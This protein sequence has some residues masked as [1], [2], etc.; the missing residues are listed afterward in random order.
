MGSEPKLELQLYGSFSCRWSDGT[1]VQIPGAKHRALLA[2]LAIGRN[3]TQSRTWLQSRLWSRSGEELG[4]QSL[5]RAISD[6]KRIFGETAYGRLFDVSN[7]DLRLRPEEVRICGGERDGPFLDGLTIR[8]PAFEEW[9]A[10]E[11]DRGRAD[12]ERPRP[13]IAISP[14]LAVVPFQ[15]IDGEPGTRDFADLFAAETTRA[16]SRSRMIDVISHL[17]CRSFSGGSLQL[18]DVRSQLD[19]DY[20]I[21]GA[22]RSDGRDFRLDADFIEAATGHIVWTHTFTGAIRDVLMGDSVIVRQIA[23]Q[24][25]Q[26]ILRSSVDLARSRPLPEVESHALFMASIA[27]MHQHRQTSFIQARRQLEE[28]IQRNPERSELYA[29][30]AKWYILAISQGWSDDPQADMQRAAQSAARGLDVDPVCSISLTVDGMIQ[31]SSLG[32]PD[33]AHSRFTEATRINP[34][35][36]LAWLMFGRMHAFLG[37]GE[38]AV[39]FTSRARALSPLDPLGYFYDAIAATAHQ[40]ADDNETARVLAE[41]SIASNP[42]HTSSYRTLAIAQELLDDHAA[43]AQT[44]ATLKR[45]E[46]DLTVSRYQARHPAGLMA[47]GQRWAEALRRAGLPER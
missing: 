2:M 7:I 31:G 43:A 38:E 25:G 1:R 10:H 35:Q 28:L 14:T 26:T 32:D 15:A 18:Q 46:P 41:R 17:S 27:Q 47:Q 44:I 36:A 45:L 40:V 24:A 8:E 13:R 37:N 19:A 23:E 12:R 34:N 29:W 3:G 42:R 9:L 16:I 39:Q 5:R 11:R 4:R 21:H 33:L 20:L 22:L 30:L 6:L